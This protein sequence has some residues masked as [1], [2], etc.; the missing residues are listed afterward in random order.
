[1]PHSVKTYAQAFAEAGY[2]ASAAEQGKIVQRFMTLVKKNGDSAKL[3]AIL[4]EAERMLV[5]M[6]G[7]KVV[8]LETARVLSPGSRAALHKTFTAKDRIEERVRPEVLAGI[9][10]CV[11]GEKEFDA[12]FKRKLDKLFN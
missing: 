1:M 3:P 8:M 9:R 5:R 2:K 4:D 11:D 10:I 6:Q 12:S 7:G